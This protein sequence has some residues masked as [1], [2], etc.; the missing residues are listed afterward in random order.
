MSDIKQRLLRATV[1]SCQCMT[2]SNE[3]EYHDE[4]CRY[5][6]LMDAHSHID[7]YDKLLLE[8]RAGSEPE[9]TKAEERIKT[10]QA[11][12]NELIMGV[13]NKYPGET[14]HQTAYRFITER[15]ST[16]SGAAKADGQLQGRE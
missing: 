4:N 13:E 15:G 11:D 1:S 8:Y 9:L 16:V 14:R 5:R 6:V 10:L 12:Y 2:K 3:S 7:M